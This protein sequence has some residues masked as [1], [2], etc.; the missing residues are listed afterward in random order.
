MDSNKQPVLGENSAVLAENELL[1][2]QRD[3]LLQLRLMDKV[4]LQ[5]IANSDNSI[6][7]C[8]RLVKQ[9]WALF[10][11]VVRPCLFWCDK[12]LTSWR[13]L[14]YLDWPEC[15]SSGAGEVA[16]PPKSLV[17]FVAS[18]SRQFGFENNLSSRLDWAD[19]SDVIQ[20]YQLDEC[21]L[22]SV[23]DSHGGWL[24]LGLFS[25]ECSVTEEEHF[26]RWAIEQVLH[27][28][29]DWV[30]A[31]LNRQSMDVI[32]QETTDKE[33]G[34]LL[35]H[36]FNNAIDMMLKDARRYFQRLAF[37]TVFVKSNVDVAELKHLSDTLTST[38]RD[39]DLLARTDE[40]E[41]V[42]AMRIAQLDDGLIVARK[43]ESALLAADPAQIAALNEGV[44]IG[45]S[46]YPE[47]AS[48]N[49]L[50]I[51]SKAAAEAVTEKTGYRLEL[52]GQFV[53]NIEDA[54]SL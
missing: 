39:N 1:L 27:S 46:F 21:A 16:H 37:V 18:P 43:I 51:T 41:F 15:C 42:M 49:R 9:V 54:Y 7:F 13:I 29:D 6:N 48:H 8:D 3:F 36:A 5:S 35:P 50:Y 40:R 10:P 2:R 30:R 4:L 19:W 14:N 28:V 25:S 22:V 47:Q 11:A 34:L 33:T 45:V 24:T 53:K 52:Y 17:T 23:Q 38:L 12:D 26:Y 31:M 44:S 20:S 32:L